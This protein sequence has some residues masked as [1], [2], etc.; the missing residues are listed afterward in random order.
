MPKRRALGD[1]ESSAQTRAELGGDTASALAG[2]VEALGIPEDEVISHREYA[3]V[4]VVVTRDGRKLTYPKS[5]Q[6]G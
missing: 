1:V 3:E 2:A 4:V 6:A 5:P